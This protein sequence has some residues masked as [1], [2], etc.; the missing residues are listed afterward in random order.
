M[1]ALL[2]NGAGLWVLQ[3]IA[4]SYGIRTNAIPRVR[5]G[6][7]LDVDIPYLASLAAVGAGSRVALILL[8]VLLRARFTV[9][10]GRSA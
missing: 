1:A 3:Q 2:L 6:I 9:G 8:L 7:A 5:Q 10:A 4:T